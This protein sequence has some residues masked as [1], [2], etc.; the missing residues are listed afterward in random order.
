L[1][2]YDGFYQ[3]G[4]PTGP[5]PI[6]PGEEADAS[7]TALDPAFRETLAGLAMAALLD[8]GLLS[9]QTSARADLAQKAG[10]VLY[11]SEE[12]RAI[13]AARLGTVEKQIEDAKTRN[14]AED[15]ALK[16]ARGEIAAADPFEAASRLKELQMQLEALYLI[17]SRVSRLSLAEYIR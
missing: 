8:R 15:T 7:I 17:T 14:S 9:G 6:A 12:K 4:P 11:S 13:L 3:G 16:I 5:I 1:G 2:G 10:M